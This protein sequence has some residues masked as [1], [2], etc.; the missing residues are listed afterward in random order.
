MRRQLGLVIVIS[1]ILSSIGLG[2]VARFIDLMLVS[3][4]SVLIIITGKTYTESH[5]QYCSPMPCSCQSTINNAGLGMFAITF[6]EEATYIMK[7]EGDIFSNEDQHF[8][9]YRNVDCEHVVE[10]QRDMF[11]LPVTLMVPIYLNQ[12]WHET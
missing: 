7:Y 1:L 4:S 11:Q 2:S 10:I 5:N 8:D 6:F 12:S 3:I 9:R